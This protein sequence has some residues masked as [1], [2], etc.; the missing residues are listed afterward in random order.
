M[1][2]GLRH[3][4]HQKKFVPFQ[5]HRNMKVLDAPSCFN[6][7]GKRGRIWGAYPLDANACQYAVATC[8]AYRL[9]ITWSKRVPFR[10]LLLP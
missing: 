5:Q 3:A 7:I 10:G 2:A 8:A 1:L 6:P 4:Y 9:G